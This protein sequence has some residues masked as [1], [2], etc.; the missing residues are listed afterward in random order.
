LTHPSARRRGRHAKADYHPVCPCGRNP[1][2]AYFAAGEQAL[3][4]ALILAQVAMS[5]L[6][7]IERD[8]SLLELNLA[9]QFIARREIEAFCGICQFRS[10]EAGCRHSDALPD[11]HEHHATIST[12]H[13]SPAH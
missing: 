2:L 13:V 10:V 6:E 9:L 11:T 5:H 4:E 12:S 8:A 1:L 3:R 7:P